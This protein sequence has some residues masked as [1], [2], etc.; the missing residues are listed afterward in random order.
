MQQS[1]HTTTTKLALQSPLVQRREAATWDIPP[2][3]PGGCP[4]GVTPNTP[5]NKTGK[6]TL[7]TLYTDTFRRSRRKKFYY[8]QSGNFS[9]L[10]DFCE[11]S[12]IYSC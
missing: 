6:L 9:I 3:V 5:K 7:V 1:P 4:R 12:Y 10:Y 11:H 8:L 2:A